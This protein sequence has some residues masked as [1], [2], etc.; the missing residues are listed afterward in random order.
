M[1]STLRFTVERH[2]EGERLRLALY[3]EL[4]LYGAPRFD[5]ELVRAEGEQW[6]EIVLDLCRLEFMDSSGLRLILRSHARAT[7]G[8]RRVR[9]VH[10]GGTIG[11]VLRITSV[12]QALDVTERASARP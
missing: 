7:Q 11:R 9:I 10:A 2:E 5:D 8:G 1:G 4:D 12:D 6:P 3:G